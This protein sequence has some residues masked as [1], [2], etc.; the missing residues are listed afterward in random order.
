MG[1]TAVL[2][3]TGVT[4]QA[5]GNRPVASA[6]DLGLVKNDMD[7]TTGNTIRSGAEV[8]TSKTVT[9]SLPQ[10]DVVVS[11]DARTICTPIALSAV[12]SDVD[13]QATAKT[14]SVLNL[15]NVVYRMH[16]LLW[17]PHDAKL[18]LCNYFN[19]FICVQCSKT[20]AL[21]L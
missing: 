21:P 17:L 14:A 10:Y 16:N 2:D 1:G 15:K 9:D 5:A 19:Y 3:S 11:S 20:Q 13:S 7:D 4:P 12:K 8:I 6:I 18:Y